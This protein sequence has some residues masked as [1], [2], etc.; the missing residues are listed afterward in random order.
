MGKGP[1]PGY[2]VTVGSDVLAAHSEGVCPD[3][4]QAVLTLTPNSFEM[5]RVLSY[6][7]DARVVGAKTKYNFN[8]T[9]FN[10]SE[11]RN[12]TNIIQLSTRIGIVAERI[13]SGDDNGWKIA[14]GTVTPTGGDQ[15]YVWNFG[16]IPANS[17]T[18]LA[19]T[20]CYFNPNRFIMPNMRF[21]KINSDGTLTDANEGDTDVILTPLERR[22]DEMID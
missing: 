9:N 20:Y 14:M 17:W 2:K 5:G 19:H 3:G 22:A 15:L 1:A 7:P 16:G 21:K 4:Y 8:L 18:V 13:T 6:N 10:I 12:A 11:V